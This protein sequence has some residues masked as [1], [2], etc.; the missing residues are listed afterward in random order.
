MSVFKCVQIRRQ[1]L[2]AKGFRPNALVLITNER[3]M[4]SI[5]YE[6]GQKKIKFKDIQGI[7][8]FY[9]MKVII[10]KDDR[11]YANNNLHFEIYEQLNKESDD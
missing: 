9:G 7:D 3:T 2:I 6:T 11:P 10:T 5:L 8:T 4:Y 1:N